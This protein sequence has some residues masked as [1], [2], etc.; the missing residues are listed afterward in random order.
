LIG[1][2]LLGWFWLTPIV[3]AASSVFE[4]LQGSFRD[5]VFLTIYLLNPMS[6]VVFGFQHALYHSVNP[7]PVLSPQTDLALGGWLLL[8]I[9]AST[10]LLYLTWRLFFN[11]SG[12]FAEEL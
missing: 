8:V 11:L 6:W 4:K 9:A 7:K 12:D 1:L 3:Y 2:A 5:K 10:A